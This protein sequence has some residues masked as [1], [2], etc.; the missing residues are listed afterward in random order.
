MNRKFLS[1]ILAFALMFGLFAGTTF[2]AANELPEDIS[3]EDQTAVDNRTESLDELQK[4]IDA[5]EKEKKDVLAQKKDAESYSQVLNKQ[6]K[7]TEKKIVKLKDSISESEDEIDS[8][9]ANIE[10]LDAVIAENL[11]KFRLRVR[12]I[13]VSSHTSELE[14]LLSSSNYMDMLTKAEIL[15]RISENDQKLINALLSDKSDVEAK[16]TQVTE[17]KEQLVV[18]K[19]DMEK[20]SRQLD[21]MYEENDDLLDELKKDEKAYAAKIKQKQ[22]E[23]E[24]VQAEI[25]EILSKYKSTLEYDGGEYAWP[26]PGFSK[27]TSPYGKRDGG[28]HTGSDI[29][30]RNA[31]GEKCLGYP[32]VSVADGVVVG[33]YNRGNASYGRYLII[34]HG[35]GRKSLYAHLSS[36]SVKAGDKITKGQTIAKAGST[37]NSTG[38]HLHIELWIDDERVDPMTILKYPG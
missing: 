38:P 2:E 6:I 32:V 5:L 37:G 8:L 33:V 12:S 20:T 28:F 36:V 16:R 13:Y 30:G 1:L 34:D 11:E 4:Q 18:E 19:A 3:E 22:K 14:V 25:D 27:I 21:D 17:K 9:T 10:A 24:E 29:A 7:T 31:K 23:V 26:L 15:R 35:S